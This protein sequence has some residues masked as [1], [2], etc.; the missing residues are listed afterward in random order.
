MLAEGLARL[1]RRSCCLRDAPVTLELPHRIPRRIACPLRRD[2]ASKDRNETPVRF[3][4]SAL[5][6][7]GMG[8]HQISN[9]Y[10]AT[11]TSED[12]V[13]VIRMWPE[14]IPGTVDVPLWRGRVTVVNTHEE[15]H[16]NDVEEA[17]EIVRAAL[18]R[19]P[20]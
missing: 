13:F 8:N 5:A 9:D 1:V 10:G 12:L 3:R 20:V 6:A 15:R 2:S 17:F 14:R 16:V 19:R 11:S 7:A 18:S 4:R